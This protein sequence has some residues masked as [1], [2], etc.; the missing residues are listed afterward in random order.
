M[1][2]ENTEEDMDKE[3]N[4]SID[5]EE[6][7]DATNDVENDD[8]ECELLD[9]PRL[10]Y[11]RLK[12]PFLQKFL[13][14]ENWGLKGSKKRLVA[15]DSFVKYI[16]SVRKL[17]NLHP[18][19]KGIFA[20]E[21]K[22]LCSGRLAIP[23]DLL[24]IYELR[25]AAHFGKQ[26]DAATKT[27]EGMIA[28]LEETF[29]AEVD[30]AYLYYEY[31][32]TDRINNFDDYQLDRPPRA[33]TG[34]WSGKDLG[35][36][37]EII[38][39]E[40]SIYEDE[41]SISEDEESI[42]E[43]EESIS[44]YEE[45]I[46]DFY[47]NFYE[48]QLEDADPVFH[49]EDVSNKPPYYV[50]N[51][52]E[53]FA[54][55]LRRLRWQIYQKIGRK[56][57]VRHSFL[58]PVRKDVEKYEGMVRKFISKFES[59]ELSEWEV[60]TWLRKVQETKNAALLEIF[61]GNSEKSD[62]ENEEE[63]ENSFESKEEIESVSEFFDQVKAYENLCSTLPKVPEEIEEIE[64]RW[65]R[66]KDMNE[67]DIVGKPVAKN[68]TKA[69]SFN[70]FGFKI[71]V[72]LEVSEMDSRE[73]F[74][75]KSS[76]EEGIND[77]KVDVFEIKTEP[78]EAKF[79]LAQPSESSYSQDPVSNDNARREFNDWFEKQIGKKKKRPRISTQSPSFPLH[80]VHKVDDS[81]YMQLPSMANREEKKTLDLFCLFQAY[82]VLLVSACK[83]L[84]DAIQTFSTLS[85]APF[86]MSPSYHPAKLSMPKP[87]ITLSS[88]FTTPM[89]KSESVSC[90]ARATTATTSRTSRTS[91]ACASELDI[92][93]TSD[94]SVP[95]AVQ[96]V[97]PPHLFVPGSALLGS[98]L[99]LCSKVKPW[100]K[101]GTVY[102]K[103]G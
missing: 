42:S 75:G 47:E 64:K 53:R 90:C 14:P 59:T 96:A 58:Y 5:E 95:R 73:T 50:Y 16:Q 103:L 29:K 24:S 65:R 87:T 40:E 19:M 76:K 82:F 37:S 43:Y 62:I 99:L 83:S 92:S 91:S 74:R 11:Y 32:E 26:K 80:S 67:F 70:K 97:P 57:S 28:N 18:N 94:I 66:L 6:V 38:E 78:L 93:E 69:S 71:P 35:V 68:E 3:E 20:E 1:K 46:S 45:F 2:K 36:A 101:G 30:L 72:E 89:S 100:R 8:E 17:V 86:P 21:V 54:Q 56:V 60:S 27:D 55:K 12:E 4:S 63:M 98:D 25:K 51:N 34:F 44:E 7:F 81:E 102:T 15:V 49:P 10:Q 61:D 52:K 88:S 79:N 31:S 9:T 22:T 33:R 41:E 23:P 39:D 48:K 84:N 13:F 77:P 85:S